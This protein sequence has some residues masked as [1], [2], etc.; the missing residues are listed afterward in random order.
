VRPYKD[1]DGIGD[2]F[3]FS[4][5]HAKDLLLAIQEAVRLYF[6]N[7]KKFTELRK[8]GMTK[9]FSWKKSAQEYLRMYGD[10]CDTKENKPLIP[11]AEAFETLK[12]AYIKVDA[13]NKKAYPERIDPNYRQIVQIRFSGRAEGTMYVAFSMGDIHVEPFSYAGADAYIE[14]SYD[15]L[16]KIAAGKVS[17]DTLF[18]NSQL[19]I[20]GNLSKGYAIRNLL[21]PARWA[22]A[23]PK[24]EKA[25]PAPEKKK[26]VPKKAKAA[27]K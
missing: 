21:A 6:G 17:V 23:A 10:I 13:A 20:S 4:D 9:D 7:E 22:K 27:A 5:Y 14:C 24:E 26:T 12:K 15:N 19:K 18:L 8:R 11:F 25:E 3:A 16:L 2:G 1:F